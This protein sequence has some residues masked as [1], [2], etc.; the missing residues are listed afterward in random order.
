MKK[1]ALIIGNGPSIDILNAS[2]LKSFTTFGCN[3]IYLKFPEWGFA[4]D[5][6]VITDSNRIREI[7]QS[8]KNY[9]GNLFI[10]D[11]RY[12]CPPYSKIKKVIGRDFVPL[13]QLPKRTYPLNY[14]TKKIK[15][16][17][18]LY[19]T[20]F[21]KKRMTFK[22]EEGLSFGSSVIFSAIQIAA[23]KGFRKILLTGV[24]ANYEEPKDYFLKAKDKI[25]YVNAT[26]QDNP[27]LAMEP[28]FVVL[29]IYFEKM[30]IDLID[31]TPKGALRFIK[32]GSLEDYV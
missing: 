17:R 1:A 31:C 23:I 18:Y 16:S 4:V 9:R 26:F 7:G 29:Q 6:V 21:D 5:N 20:I 13:Q 25:S 30:G 19:A 24:D 11:E 8:Y 22:F 32:K 14:L 2:V 15:F 3:H 10:G 12:I 27:R 28:F